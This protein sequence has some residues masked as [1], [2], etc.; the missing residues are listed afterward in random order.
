MSLDLRKGRK[1][2]V[3]VIKISGSKGE[4]EVIFFWGGDSNHHW[5]EGE[6][7]GADVGGLKVIFMQLL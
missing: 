1:G 2:S 5:L 7:T 6:V 3:W 4:L